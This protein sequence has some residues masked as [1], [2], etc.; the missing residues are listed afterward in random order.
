MR[1]TEVLE[2]QSPTQ[3]A[4]QREHQRYI[5]SDSLVLIRRLSPNDVRRL[6]GICTEI[7][8]GAMSTIVTEPLN[9]GEEVELTFD[10]EPGA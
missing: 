3:Y 1:Y 4:V 7:S 2:L 9:I 10:L 6:P 8:E 5:F